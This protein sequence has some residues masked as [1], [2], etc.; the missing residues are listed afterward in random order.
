MTLFSR[1]KA[2]ALARESLRQAQIDLLQSEYY[3]EHYQSNAIMLQGR[4]KRLEEYLAR[5]EPA[6]LSRIPYAAR[7]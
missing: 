1:V 5:A 7:K 2:E 3:A 6:N 4:I